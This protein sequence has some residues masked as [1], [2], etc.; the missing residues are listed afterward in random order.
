MSAPAATR[1]LT[2]AMPL[3]PA[4]LSPNARGHHL[5]RARATAAYR[6]DCRKLAWSAAGEPRAS[7]P[8][9]WIAPARA[10]VSLDFATGRARMRDGLYRPRDQ[11]N[12]AA[13][14]K[15]LF[16]A[17]TDAGVIVSDNHLCMELG[18]VVIRPYSTLE[19]GPGVLVTV[20]AL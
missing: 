17:L 6:E 2:I 16:D 18:T 12:A 10:R 14:V 1:T 5:P 3:P 15:A 9:Y 11:D 8:G 20:E 13:S 4:A 7:N 19:D